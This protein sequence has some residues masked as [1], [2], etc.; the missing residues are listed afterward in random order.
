MSEI[1]RKITKKVYFTNGSDG[2]EVNK[3]ILEFTQKD[4]DDL[5]AHQNHLESN[6]SGF[7]T[8][9]YHTGELVDDEGE[10]SE[11]RTDGG[12]IDIY[13]TYFRYTCESK[14]DGTIGVD[15][16]DIPFTELF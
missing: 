7:R 13:G 14:Y 11:F 3:V 10:E 9:M 8:S 15:S 2:S 6:P 1:V 12:I 5:K 4:L 16:E